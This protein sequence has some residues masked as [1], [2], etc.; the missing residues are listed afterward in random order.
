MLSDQS[1]IKHLR[2]NNLYSS[3]P[4]CGSS[5]NANSIGKVTSRLDYRNHMNEVS[6]SLYSIRRFQLAHNAATRVVQK[7]VSH[8]HVF[9]HKTTSIG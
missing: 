9:S 2:K 4:D 5:E 6:D 1:I 7:N 3:T 8:A